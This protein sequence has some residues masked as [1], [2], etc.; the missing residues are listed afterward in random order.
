MLADIP[1]SIFVVAAALCD[2]TGRVLLQRRP[3][4]KHHGGAWEFPGGKIENGENPRFAL[5][6]ELAEEL[7]IVADPE[8]FAAMAF[9]EEGTEHPIVLLLYTLRSWG[10]AIEGREGQKWGWFWLEQAENL[11]L[12]PMDRELLHK[13]AA[14]GLAKP[15]TAP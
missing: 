3:L 4:H 15:P 2:E 5:A 13:L 9:A 14:F 12:A 10:N 6:R 1:T 11:P 8:D 7:G